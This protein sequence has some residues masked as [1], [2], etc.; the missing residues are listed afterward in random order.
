M[1]RRTYDGVRGTATYFY[2]EHPIDADG[3]RK[4]TSLGSDLLKAKMKWAEMERVSITTVTTVDERSL[5]A[6]HIRYTEWANDK[7]QSQLSDR[8]LQDRRKYW[9]QLGP[10]YGEMCMDDFKPEYFMLYFDRRSAKSSAKKELKFLSVIFNWARARGFM[11]L[12]NPLTGVIRQ[13]KVKEGRDIYVTDE[14]LALV[15]DCAVP[16]I[17]DAIDL[18]YLTG[19]R[20]ADVLKMRW[21]QVR[22]GSVWIEQGKT[23]AKLQ[24]AIEGGLAK[25]IDRIKSR[26]IIGMTLLVDPKGQ[27]LKPFGYF[28]SQF[29]K[30]R[31]LAE[32]RAAELGVEFTRFQFKDLRAKSA[33]DMETMA[34]ARKL[35]GH[36]TESMTAK[37]VRTR[38]G[39]RVS[40]IQR[41]GYDKRKNA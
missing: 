23:K 7:K 19:Q 16:V 33:S 13:M 36:S 24:I 3:K 27:Q 26:G 39:E 22:D 12:A 17:Q 20:P 10:I 8:T 28:R 9:K 15:Y 30:A 1:V 35:L 38:V 34:N 6:V 40:P 2:Y 11:K 31:D 5:A 37:Y 29:D 14:M 41:S 32:K 4:L 21:D 25:V 18:A